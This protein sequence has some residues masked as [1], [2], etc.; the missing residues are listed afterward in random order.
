M[1]NISA[2]AAQT[3]RFSW[4]PI[5][6]KTWADVIRFQRYHETGVITR[7]PDTAPIWLE[8]EDM[9]LFFIDPKKCVTHP[10]VDPVQIMPG[11]TELQLS[12]ALQYKINNSASAKITIAENLRI[13]C[14]GSSVT[15]GTGFLQDSMLDYLM[16]YL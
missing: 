11:I 15:W 10:F 14:A 9:D 16:P 5:G 7:V 4:M 1:V 13:C 8:I 6:G 2:S 12:D 3:L